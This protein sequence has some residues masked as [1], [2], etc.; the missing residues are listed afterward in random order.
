VGEAQS[1]V[2]PSGPRFEALALEHLPDLLGAAL[3]MTG[4]QEEAQDLCCQALKQA[5][6][7]LDGAGRPPDTRKWLV[8]ILAETYFTTRPPH[9]GRRVASDPAPVS[10]SD[11]KTP[12]AEV[13]PKQRLQTLLDGLPDEMRIPVLLH[14]VEGL[15]YQE[16]ARALSIPLGSVRSRIFHGRS[17]LREALA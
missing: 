3:R 13:P 7:R 2:L 16:I 11:A 17:R 14:D 15:A 1:R 12:P 10:A 6:R 8:G 5:Y 9:D 4:D